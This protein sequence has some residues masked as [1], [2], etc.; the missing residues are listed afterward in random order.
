MKRGKK[1]TENLFKETVAQVF[2]NL[3]KSIHLNKNQQI[4]SAIKV[5][6]DLYPIVIV[7]MLKCNY[8]EKNN[9]SCIEDP[10]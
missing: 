1:R 4:L 9:L 6:R 3:M 2:P 5:Q 7:K 8:K 10:H